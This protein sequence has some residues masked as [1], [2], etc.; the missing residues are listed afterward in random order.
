[1]VSQQALRLD[2]PQQDAVN[3]KQSAD[4]ERWLNEAITAYQKTSSPRLSSKQVIH[5]QS[6]ACEAAKECLVVDNHNLDAMNILARVALDQ[7]QLDKAEGWVQKAQRIDR[8]FASSW[9]SLGQIKLAQQ[10][11]MAAE[12]AFS[13]CIEL[14]NN[15][16]RAHTSYAYTKLLQGDLVSA[17]EY[18]RR[19]AR[20]QPNDAHVRSKLFECLRKLQADCDNPSL[21]DDLISYLKWRDVNHND[22]ARMITSLLKH[23]YRVSANAVVDLAVLAKDELFLLAM[24]RLIFQDA[25]W[26]VFLCDIRKYL[27]LNELQ[28]P[29]TDNLPLLAAFCGQAAN[30]EYAFIESDQEINVLEALTN[31][32]STADNL[33]GKPRPLL[34]A[35]MYRPLE[36]LLGPELFHQLLGSDK[37]QWDLEFRNIMARLFKQQTQEEAVDIKQ[38]GNITDPVSR[39]VKGQYEDNPYPRWLALEH[40]TPTRYSDALEAVLPGFK[41]PKLLSKGKL[42]VLIAGCGTGRHA[43]N[44]ARYFRDVQVLAVDISHNSLSYAQRMAKRYQLDNVEFLQADILQLEGLG[45]KFDIIECSGVLHHMD[46]PKLGAQCL[47]NILEPKGLLKIGLYSELARS[48]VVTCRDFIKRN[49]IVAN[50]GGIRRLRNEIISTKEQP[51]QWHEIRKSSDFYSVSGCR[52]LLFHVKEWRFT[53]NKINELCK[54]LSLTFLG[55]SSLDKNTIENYR[56]EFP[57]DKRLLNLEN[58]NEFEDKNQQTFSSM[59]QFYVQKRT[60]G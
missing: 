59:Y 33:Q 19:L 29:C 13:H 41:S 32:L 60:K 7:G 58:W 2:I 26:E 8:Q 55:F 23:R 45:R 28:H 42:Q 44:V 5:L 52:D 34:L 25:E 43:L 46:D 9:F 4:I 35:S 17:F 48:S 18:Y 14:D 56:L 39:V 1:M 36:E 15:I 6:H 11:L 16:F 24:D 57:T 51:D 22:L 40:H 30:N 10:D 47:I 53:T 49:K 37:N 3:T 31:Q 54:D 27:L 12:K 38:F 21:S 20:A 50:S